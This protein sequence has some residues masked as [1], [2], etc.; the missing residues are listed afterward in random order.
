MDTWTL[1]TAW[2]PQARKAAGMGTTALIVWPR[3]YANLAWTDGRTMAHRSYS[4]RRVDCGWVAI[5]STGESSRD[6]QK[7][8]G[9]LED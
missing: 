1:D 9:E 6:A 5:T 4:S 2:A 8:S 3:A 7:K